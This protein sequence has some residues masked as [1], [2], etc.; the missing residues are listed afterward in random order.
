MLFHRARFQSR[1]YFLVQLVTNPNVSLS[2]LE[3]QAPQKQEVKL[4]HDQWKH[5]ASQCK[6]NEAIVPVSLVSV[7]WLTIP[8]GWVANENSNSSSLFQLGG[9]RGDAIRY[10]CCSCVYLDGCTKPCFFKHRRSQN[11]SNKIIIFPILPSQSPFVITP[12]QNWCQY[13][14]QTI[15]LCSNFLLLLWA[16]LFPLHL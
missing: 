9:E 4:L 11:N 7:K 12:T 16:L 15:R 10:L 2:A 6:Q 5:C 14:A 3:T 8:L 1:E 13:S